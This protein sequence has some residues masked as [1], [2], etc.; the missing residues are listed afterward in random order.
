MPP[1]YCTTCV[2]YARLNTYSVRHRH[3]AYVRSTPLLFHRV[4]VHL[5]RYATYAVTLRTSDLDTGFFHTDIWD[6][7]GCWRFTSTIS[8][9]F[10]IAYPQTQVPVP[11]VPGPCADT[12]APVP[13]PILDLL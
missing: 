8:P 7:P 13:Q 11:S 10:F 3:H 12:T 2:F 9:L 6:T 4:F 1:V 5:L